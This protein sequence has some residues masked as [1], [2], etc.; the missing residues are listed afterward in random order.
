MQDQPTRDRGAG[1]RRPTPQPTDPSRRVR[2]EIV[3]DCRDR[4]VGGRLAAQLEE[5][6][7][8]SASVRRSE[9]GPTTWAVAVEFPDR[10]GIDAFFRS[11]GYRQFCIEVR[12]AS[13][14][15]VLVVPLGE[16]EEPR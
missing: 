16:I 7:A 13:R 15:S 4:A 3:F 1:P 12:R 9:D 6:A 2:Y 10:S 8:A 11:D 14:S 5:I